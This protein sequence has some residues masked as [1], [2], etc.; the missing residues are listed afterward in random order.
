MQ[1]CVV[2]CEWLALG[3]PVALVVS[4]AFVVFWMLCV[5]LDYGSVV[6]L[7]RVSGR[8]RLAAPRP[9]MI[10]RTTSR[11]MARTVGM[12]QTSMIPQNTVIDHPL[13]GPTVNVLAYI[14]K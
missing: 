11:N 12:I 4:V 3:L 5:L 6:V 8:D 9:P 14:R 13:P 10:R 7:G 2:F 1:R